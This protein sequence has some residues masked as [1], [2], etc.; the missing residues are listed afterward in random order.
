MNR[1]QRRAQAAQRTRVEDYCTPPGRCSMTFDV[2]GRSP[3]TIEI[4]ADLLSLAFRNSG[5]EA[6]SLEDSI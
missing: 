1:Q 3:S 2:G 4:I 6:K 5:G